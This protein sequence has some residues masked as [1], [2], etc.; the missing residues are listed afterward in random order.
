MRNLIGTLIEQRFSGRIISDLLRDQYTTGKARL[1]EKRLDIERRLAGR[2]GQVED[3]RGLG[4]APVEVLF[5]RSE[6]DG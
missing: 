4:P 1:I 6:H 2:S 5:V 3:W